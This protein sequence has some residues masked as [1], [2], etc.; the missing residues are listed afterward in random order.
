MSMYKY[1]IGVCLTI[2]VSLGLTVYYLKGRID[3][4]NED[5]RLKD[6]AIVSIRN[7]YEQAL[8]VE[9]SQVTVKVQ[10]H[11]IEKD[12]TLKELIKARGEVQDDEY[13]VKIRF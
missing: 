12:D 6:D 8:S 3:S 10:K 4:L 1:I 7:G 2:V 13:T 9:R 5:V 11:Y